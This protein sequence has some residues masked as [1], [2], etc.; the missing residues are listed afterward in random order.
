MNLL[1]DIANTLAFTIF[2]VIPILV[3]LVVF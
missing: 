1:I 2:D 3:T